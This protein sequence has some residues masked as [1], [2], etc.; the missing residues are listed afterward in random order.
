MI[1]IS[2]YLC[3]ILSKITLICYDL[4]FQISPGTQSEMSDKRTRTI[5]TDKHN[6]E[7]LNSRYK[8]TI[9]A[10]HDLMK[11]AALVKYRRT[12]DEVSKAFARALENEQKWSMKFKMLQAELDSNES[13]MKIALELSERDKNVISSLQN[14]LKTAWNLVEELKSK[15]KEG[16]RRD[17]AE[18]EEKTESERDGSER[19]RGKEKNTANSDKNRETKRKASDSEKLLEEMLENQ[20]KLQNEIERMKLQV[21]ELE[22]E[23]TNKEKVIDELTCAL[24][25]KSKQLEVVTAKN[26]DLKKL[27]D[28]VKPLNNADTVKYE[29]KLD[30]INT[31]SNEQKLKEIINNLKKKLQDISAKDQISLEKVKHLIKKNQILSKQLQTTKNHNNLLKLEM[32]E[33][34]KMLDLLSCQ[35]CK[36]EER[37]KKQTVT[38]TEL[39]NIR[40]KYIHMVGKLEQEIHEM[41]KRIKF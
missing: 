1:F 4:Y 28:E 35:F 41:R 37:G 38:I 17:I 18:D 27:L 5:F 26:T 13:R 2:F 24:N 10:L 40:N 11:D 19:S 15:N 29:K 8:N 12:L 31:N 7:G 6:Q 23:L 32:S 25:S 9:S 34:T 21:F 14:E 16:F 3:I 30:N 22:E 36:L 39:E 33:R 20:D